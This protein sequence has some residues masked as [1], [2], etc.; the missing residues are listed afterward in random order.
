VSIINPQRQWG[1]KKLPLVGS[2]LL[3][4]NFSS[5]VDNSFSEFRLPKAYVSG[6]CAFTRGKRH[7][8]A[9]CGSIDEL[10][11]VPLRLAPSNNADPSVFP[12][13]WGGKLWDS[14]P[15]QKSEF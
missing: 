7:A 3:L 5:W 4:G 8:H 15:D 6:V 12:H 14:H 13:P 2:C 11:N 9:K 1:L 10:E